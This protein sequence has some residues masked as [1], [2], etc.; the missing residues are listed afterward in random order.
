MKKLLFSVLAA[1][2]LVA[3]QKDENNVTNPVGTNESELITTLRVELF[4]GSQP[5]VFQFK[6]LDG[7]GGA[8][9]TV[10]TIVLSK[11]QVFSCDLVFLDESNSANVKDL[12]PEIY[13]ERNDHLICYTSN[14]SQLT[15]EVTDKDQNNLPV[16]LAA[17]WTTASAGKGSITIRLK[18][19]PGIKTGDCA[20]GETDLEVVFP[21]V[22]K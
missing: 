21:V 17:N 4:D 11:D 10:D 22:V 1:F 18:H 13:S 12:T 6:D 3:C 14:T 9:A 15:I 7:E 8:N 20:L 5:M 19:Q 16:G 2:T